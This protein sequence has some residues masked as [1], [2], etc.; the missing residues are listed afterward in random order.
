M[1]R[2]L[3]AVL[4]LALIGGQAIAAGS[5][6]YSLPGSTQD[7]RNRRTVCQALA[8]HDRLKC[9]SVTGDADLKHLC[10][11]QASG[12]PRPCYSISTADG[13]NYCKGVAGGA[14]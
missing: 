14:R 1:T 13:R 2:P 8:N 10:E 4:V 6:C 7:E 9:A 3:A 5:S 11:A 12:D